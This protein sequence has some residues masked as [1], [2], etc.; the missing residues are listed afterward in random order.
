M[1]AFVLRVWK[2]PVK[3]A[4]LFQIPGVRMSL[5]DAAHQPEGTEGVIAPAAEGAQHRTAL[6][7]GDPPD[8]RGV[9]GAGH[10][11]GI[12]EKHRLPLRQILPGEL[13][14]A[15]LEAAVIDAGGKADAVIVL[16][17]DG[18]AGGHIDELHLA[19]A[20]HGLQELQG[21]SVVAG[22]VADGSFHGPSPP[23]GG[24]DAAAGAGARASRV[25]TITQKPAAI[26]P[27]FSLS[28]PCA[29]GGTAR[30]P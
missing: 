8:G 16:Q 29:P 17:P 5:G 14:D 19:L 24:G 23:C 7:S 25:F 2:A 11:A 9:A 13:E 22:I 15:L 4:G 21:I 12:D 28:R 20:C 10:A 26:Q 30:R 3:P 27:A 6:F 18:P 1:H